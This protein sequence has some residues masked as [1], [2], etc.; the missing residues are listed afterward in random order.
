MTPPNTWRPGLDVMSSA[1]ER[2]TNDRRPV[3]EEG[4][5]SEG[6]HFRLCKV[7]DLSLGGAFLEVGWGALTRDKPVDLTL[8][9]RSDH[10]PQVYRLQAEVARVSTEGAAVRFK[11]LDETTYKALSSFLAHTS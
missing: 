3:T 4:M 1:S 8:T 10:E 6:M 5:L 2:R 7:R 11:L 9:L